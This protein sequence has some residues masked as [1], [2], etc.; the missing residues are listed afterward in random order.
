MNVALI[1]VATPR[2]GDSQLKEEGKVTD[3]RVLPL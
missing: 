2:L 3:K 1:C